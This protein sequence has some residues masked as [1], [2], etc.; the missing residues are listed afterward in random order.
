MRAKI[1]LLF[2]FG[3]L[4]RFSY[5]ADDLKAISCI[6]EIKAETYRF[7][8]LRQQIVLAQNFPTQLGKLK[9]QLKSSTDE[10]KLNQRESKPGLIQLNMQNQYQRMTDAISEYLSASASSDNK[11]VIEINE[12]QDILIKLADEITQQLVL[13]SANPFSNGLVL[14]GSAK[15]NVEKLVYDFES[16][17]KNCAQLLPLGV[18]AVGKSIEDMHATLPKYFKK[19]SYD[20]AKNQLI[21]FNMSVTGRLRG[22]TSEYTKTNLI[23]TSGYLWQI[24]DEVLDSY[25]EKAGN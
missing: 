17:N 19:T 13:K 1:F 20:L 14:I 12:K 2:F 10:L 6:Y 18:A 21:F 16:C 23:V 4:S 5:A 8:R 7:A 15:V 3:L 25:T 24:I 22:D 11:N 9:S